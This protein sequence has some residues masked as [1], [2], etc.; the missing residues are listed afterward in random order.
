MGIIDVVLLVIIGI[1]AFRG[2]MKGLVMEVFG[3]VALGVGFSVAYAYSG[4]FSKG[5]AVMGLSENTDK[6]M[7]YVIAFV[8]SYAAMIFI[9]TFLS[10]MFKEVKLG[11]VNQGGGAAFGAVKAA[12]ITGLMLSTLS[13]TL[14]PTSEISMQ[15]SE[16]PVSSKLATLAP[17]IYDNINKIPDT[18]K[19]NPFHVPVRAVRQSLDSVNPDQVQNALNKTKDAA[20][21]LDN[22]MNQT[23]EPQQ[24][25]D[26]KTDKALENDFQ[27]N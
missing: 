17:V 9:G 24:K 10:R 14:P 12:A 21:S 8:A 6:A 7:G 1:T 20:D 25:A 5:V 3:L 4:V 22:A 18:K 15:I 16:G 23:D 19:E 11:W 2:F 13:T 27:K 26:E